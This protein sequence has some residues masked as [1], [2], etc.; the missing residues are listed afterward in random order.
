MTHQP[1]QQR[2]QRIPRHPLNPNP[3]NP[4]APRQAAELGLQNLRDAATRVFSNSSG[5]YS[6][7]VN[8]AVENSSWSDESQLQARAEIL[9]SEPMHRRKWLQGHMRAC[10]RI[11]GSGAQDPICR[12]YALAHLHA[13]CACIPY[14]SIPFHVSCISCISTTCIS[15]SQEMYMQ[16]KSFAFNS[17]RPGAGGEMKRDVFE[18][19]VS[20]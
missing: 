4:D 10:V 3:L 18:V 9:S 8:L 16:R 17:D 5:S 13:I 2:Q 20:D 11:A 1:R 6:S 12:K 7:N 19:S 14:Q 15:A